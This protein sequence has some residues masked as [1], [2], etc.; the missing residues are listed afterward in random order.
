LPY[1]RAPS[2]AID[3]YSAVDV[4]VGEPRLRIERAR[5]HV[6]VAHTFATELR[7]AQPGGRVETEGPEPV[8]VL[9]APAVAAVAIDHLRRSISPLGGHAVLPE[10]GRLVHVRVRV[11]DRDSEVPEARERGGGHSAG[12]SATISE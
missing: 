3:G 4:E 11:D 10:V 2:S 8:A 7:D 12:F 6:G 5:A 9:E 1:T